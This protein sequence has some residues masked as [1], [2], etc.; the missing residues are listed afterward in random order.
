MRDLYLAGVGC[1]LAGQDWA[2]TGRAGRLPSTAKLLPGWAGPLIG[3]A[4]PLT[5]RV[6]SLVPDRTECLYLAGLKAAVQGADNVRSAV[7]AG[8]GGAELQGARVA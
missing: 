6:G 2:L 3:R 8:G 1:Y 4:G 7:Q 5:G